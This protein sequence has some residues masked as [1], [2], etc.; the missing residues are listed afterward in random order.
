MMNAYFSFLLYLV[1]ILGF[2]GLTL[3]LNSVLGPKPEPTALK[4]E[5][6]ECGATPVQQDNTTAVSVK[7]YAIAVVFI[8]FDLETVFLFIW[9]LAAQPLTTFMLA[10][11]GL[12][13][14]L[15]VVIMLYVWRS[16]LLEEVAQ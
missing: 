10:T 14:L 13:I 5:P 15:L 2:T 12:F 3:W 6:F 9:A 16:G 4:L 8:L 7:Y 1:V 11:L